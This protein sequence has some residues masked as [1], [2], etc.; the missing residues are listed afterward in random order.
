MTSYGCWQAHAA[1]AFPTCLRPH[2]SMWTTPPFQKLHC[3]A[4]SASTQEFPL[5]APHLPTAY[6]LVRFP[7]PA[8]A[9]SVHKTILAIK[10]FFPNK[11]VCAS[12]LPVEQIKAELLWLEAGMRAWGHPHGESLQSS[13]VRNHQQFPSTSW[14][15]VHLR[16]P[17]C[18]LNTSPPFAQ[19]SHR[20]PS[21]SSFPAT[22][23]VTLYVQSSFEHLIIPQGT[24][25]RLHHCT[26]ITCLLT[27]L[28]APLDCDHF[29]GR[30]DD[31]NGV[32]VCVHA[33]MCL[34]VMGQ[35]SPSWT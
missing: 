25:H 18:S 9:L 34:H 21:R 23:L 30:Q 1:F 15:E 13:R 17:L 29:K 2:T 11:M 22:F 28:P 12:H 4:S 8:L 24:L 20:C 27:F 32:S 31:D 19:Q 35:G 3:S 7:G 6:A 10:S 16:S 5:L 14:C 26:H 33:C